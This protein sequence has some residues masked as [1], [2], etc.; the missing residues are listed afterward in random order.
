MTARYTKYKSVQLQEDMEKIK[1]SLK[2]KL[3]ITERYPTKERVN[4]KLDRE[5]CT[6]VRARVYHE[7]FQSVPLPKTVVNYDDQNA[8]LKPGVTIRKGTQS[9]LVKTVK[10]TCSEFD[11][12]RLK[13]IASGKEKVRQQRI[14]DAFHNLKMVIPQHLYVGEKLSKVKILR[15][16]RR[17]IDELSQM[18]QNDTNQDN[19]N[20][21][22]SGS[23]SMDLGDCQPGSKGSVD[24]AGTPMDL[25]VF[26]QEAQVDDKTALQAHYESTH[27]NDKESLHSHIV[28]VGDRLFFNM[29]SPEKHSN[30][31]SNG[32]HSTSTPKCTSRPVFDPDTDCFS[33]TSSATD[34]A[35]EGPGYISTCISP[36]KLD[37]E[38]TPYVR[39]EGPPWSGMLNMRQELH[40]L[41]TS[42]SQIECQPTVAEQRNMPSYPFRHY[43]NPVETTPRQMSSFTT[44]SVCKCKVC[45]TARA[46]ALQGS[47]V[48]ITSQQSLDNN[49]RHGSPSYITPPLPMVVQMWLN[50]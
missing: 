33:N 48:Y 30:T 16:A 8:D 28:E 25:R 1:T 40:I 43:P 2:R 44:C 34:D 15:V 5:I 27:S 14:K 42:M 9:S 29:T 38:N 45:V 10:Y 6:S 17:Y 31:T 26:K 3:T 13:A 12:K 47:N 4:G 23:K 41:P 39:Q 50:L 11:R 7:D 36:R 24:L 22:G 19:N 32:P 35:L 46:R 49:Q 21:V 18:L 20:D 37:F